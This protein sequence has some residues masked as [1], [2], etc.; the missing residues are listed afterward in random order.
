MTIGAFLTKKSP[1][2]IAEDVSDWGRLC[3]ELTGAGDPSPAKRLWELLSDDARTAARAAGEHPGNADRAVVLKGINCAMGRPDFYRRESFAG[4][5]LAKDVRERIEGGLDELDVTEILELNRRLI[6][7]SFP[8]NVAEL[9]GQ[10]RAGFRKGDTVLAA[11]GEKLVSWSHFRRVTKENPGTPLEIMLRRKAA[12]E[13][14]VETVIAVPMPLGGW[15]PGCVSGNDLYVESVRNGTVASAAGIKAGDRIVA[16]NGQPTGGGNRFREAVGASGGKTITVGVDRDGSRMSFQMTPET[17][18]IEKRALIGVMF[19]LEPVVGEVLPGSP[20][21]RTGLRAG[22]VL[23]SLKLQGSGAE[24]EIET[25]NQFD[26]R[27]NHG[28]GRAM[29]LSWSRNG[30]ALGG[31]LVPEY[32]PSRTSGMLGLR[33]EMKLKLTRLGLFE[34]IWY[35]IKSSYAM[36]KRV[37]GTIYGLLS[38]KVSPKVVAG[39]VLLPVMGMWFVERGL[40]T[41]LYFLGMIGINFAIVN[42]LPLPVVDGGV[43]LLIGVEKLRGKP[44]SL[45]SQ[46]II[47]QVGVAILVAIFL[48]ITIQDVG[49]LSSLFGG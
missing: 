26:G 44:L 9:S 1:L 40:G 2:L 13:D 3:R 38:L 31:T 18:T 23:L 32:D 16:L 47:Q 14:D 24:E 25:W 28:G 12:G 29:T 27:V 21:E 45:K 10:E 37:I 41:F 5:T 39:P 22:D 17:D 35:G 20:A 11:G 36:G 43:L 15:S 46:T 34:S 19:R 49:R 42:L 6:E 33:P 4:V 30:K 8:G 7:L 48:L